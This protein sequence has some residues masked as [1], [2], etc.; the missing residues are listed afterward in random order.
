MANLDRLYQSYLE[1]PSLY[2][3]EFFTEVR[4]RVIGCLRRNPDEP[5][6]EYA[7][8]IAQTVCVQL[9]QL[10]KPVRDSFTKWLNAAV[11]NQRSY[12][13]RLRIRGP[14][15]WPEPSEDDDGNSVPFDPAAQDPDAYDRRVLP[16]GLSDAER[17][18]AE[19]VFEGRT[20]Q[21]LADHEGV[22]Y[23]TVASRFSRLRAKCTA[24]RIALSELSATA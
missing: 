19:N 16:E 13:W 21:E 6:Y 4:A 20:V 15:Q 7:Q 22:S 17:H 10:K 9:L 8:D 5:A 24:L 11:A 12:A 3:E 1:D 18:L 14:E 2:G 23:S